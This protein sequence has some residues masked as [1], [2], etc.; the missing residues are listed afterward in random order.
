M[1]LNSSSLALLSLASEVQEEEPTGYSLIQFLGLL[2]QNK[3]SHMQYHCS[4]L[5]RSES[6]G[7]F[8]QIRPKF[9]VAEMLHSQAHTCRWSQDL[10][11]EGR[12]AVLLGQGSPRPR[13]RRRVKLCSSHP[14][15]PP[16]ERLLSSPSHAFSITP[17]FS[18][19][20]YQ[21]GFSLLLWVCS[22]IIRREI[23]WC[24][25]CVFCPFCSKCF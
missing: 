5:A 4:N 13:L 11:Q 18:S 24:L 6:T 1:A 17:L 3:R 14:L 16:K 2:T 12:A 15:L 21:R 20:Y 8:C 10:V 25:S 22:Q 19:H 9:S 23:C 7:N